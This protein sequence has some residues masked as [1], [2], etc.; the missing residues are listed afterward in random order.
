MEHLI[1]LFNSVYPLTNQDINLLRERLFIQTIDKNT[2]H[3]YNGK[4][5]KKLSF[6][7]SGIFKVVKTD[8][9]G[10]S[11]IPYFI[12]SGHFAVDIDSFSNK[13]NSEEDIIS[14][15]PSEIITI[16]N[17]DY[18]YFEKEIFSFSKIISILKE[19]ALLEKMK[20]KSEMLIDDATTKYKKLRQ[21]QPEII[22]QV[23]QNEI[24]LHL[25]ISQYTLSRIKSKK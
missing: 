11:Y 20:F 17:I 14:L 10:N 15:I 3:S 2:I 25:G 8:E 21:R 1:A 23:S 18:D 13:T 24:A 5:C 4:I 16:T 7:K 22:Q 6:V 12:T 9:K 19:R